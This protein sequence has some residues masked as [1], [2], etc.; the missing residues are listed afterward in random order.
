MNL[1]PSVRSL[2]LWACL[3]L[4]KLLFAQTES[5]P[6]LD[7]LQHLYRTAESD[8]A[9]IMRA[10]DIAEYYLYTNPDTALS[11]THTQYLK[12]RELD[13]PRGEAR[14]LLCDANTKLLQGYAS[15]S[16]I[17]RLTYGLKIVEKLENNEALKIDYQF[18]LGTANMT[19][20]K[21]PAALDF[22]QELLTAQTKIDPSNTGAILGQIAVVHAYMKNDTLAIT[23]GLRAIDVFKKNNDTEQLKIETLNLG[24][25]YLQIGQDSLALVYFY[26]SLHLSEA[27]DDRYNLSFVKHSFARLS[28]KNGKYDSALI[29]FGE[30]EV[31]SEELGLVEGVAEAL[32]GK[33]RVYEKLGDY[34]KS[35]KLAKK[36]EENAQK[37]SVAE[38]LLNSNEQLYNSYKAQGNYAEALRYHEALKTLN[39]SIYTI[40]KE[41]AMNNLETQGIVDRKNFEVEQAKAAQA[42]QQKI[43]YLIAA[44]AV[45]LLLFML[46]LWKNRRKI[47]R[48]YQEL[49]TSNQ[50]VLQQKEEITQTLEIVDSQ[51]RDIARKNKEITASINHA[52][53]I[54]NAII[55]TEQTLRKYLDCFVLFLPKSI[56]SG[57]FYY[58]AEV[59]KKKIFILADCTG[60]G[61][62]G[63]FMTLIG[64]NILNRIIHGSQITAPDQ[65]LNRMSPLL[66]NTL[67]YARRKIDDGMDISVL[68]VEENDNK[69]HVEYSGAMNPLYVVRNNTFSVVAANKSTI[70]S[71]RMSKKGFIY[72]KEQ[73]EID[74]NASQKTMLYLSTDGYQDQF[75]GKSDKKFL[76]KHF[77]SLLHKIADN[78]LDTQ[79]QIL[80]TTFND[81]KARTNQTDDV[82]VAGISI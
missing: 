74:K 15:D 51:H 78:P 69:I 49:S 50:L 7:S 79:K 40:D 64:N 68:T 6:T 32:I 63:A 70:G 36:A 2:L 27:T 65:I 11:I 61:V 71:G 31:I 56:V 76:R 38:L 54:Q 18:S 14:T 57:D 42:F 34:E 33:A 48:A 39:D 28:A 82:C 44:F 1:P 77:R 19:L 58:F 41:K 21:Y 22:F 29:Y 45:L 75:G 46:F 81:W 52:L 60:H 16:L 8:T 43:N 80:T 23:Y 5:S 73:L 24:T 35:I 55:P 67:R 10:L 59:N 13:Y 20:G 25:N 62:S 12:S 47:K 72:Q 3:L 66:Q 53:R 9:K 26:Q 37:I 17:E 4:P 30:A